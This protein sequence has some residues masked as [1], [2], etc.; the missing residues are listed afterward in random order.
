[1]R[2][3]VR[4]APRVAES[5]STHGH[6]VDSSQFSREDRHALQW[7]C[8]LAGP[9]K[10]AGRR[11]IVGSSQ[12]RA[13]HSPEGGARVRRV[14][15]APVIMSSFFSCLRILSRL[16]RV[17]RPINA[18][19]PKAAV[20]A[21]VMADT[22][23]TTPTLVSVDATI[24]VVTAFW[25]A[26]TRP[27]ARSASRARTRSFRSPLSSF[28]MVPATS[29]I[30]LGPVNRF[31]TARFCRPTRLRK[32]SASLATWGRASSSRPRA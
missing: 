13:A 29:S 9:G 25:D 23:S 30:M 6:G 22:D 14:Q 24:A 16:T 21:V 7:S 19:P 20:A 27:R 11:K 31:F 26:C 10:P 32:V 15:A 4:D 2:G 28:F 1:M 17:M 12:C 8:A 3:Q 18:A 5:C